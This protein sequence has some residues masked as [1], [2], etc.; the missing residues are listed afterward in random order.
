MHEGLGVASASI[1]GERTLLRPVSRSDLDLLERWLSHPDVYRWWGG[2]PLTREEVAQKY[3]GGRRPVVESLIIESGGA[4]VGYLEYSAESEDSGGID[5]FIAPSQQGQGL[6][7]DA[8]RAI[9]RHLMLDCKWRRVT[10]DPSIRNER[11]IRAW[12][13]AGFRPERQ[14]PSH[15]DGPALLMAIQAPL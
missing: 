12:T 4:P 11:A 14:L 13:K 3:I 2:S 5:M 15:P 10:V 9:V 6:G 1:R 7:P 8:A